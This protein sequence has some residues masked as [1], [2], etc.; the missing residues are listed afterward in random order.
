MAQYQVYARKAGGE[1]RY[2]DTFTDPNIAWAALNLIRSKPGWSA[3]VI[4]ARQ[5]TIGIDTDVLGE[6]NG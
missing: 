3:K 4:I 1:W 2:G 5:P 6:A